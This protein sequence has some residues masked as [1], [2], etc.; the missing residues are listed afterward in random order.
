M[1][2]RGR[3]RYNPTIDYYLILGVSHAATTDEI[4]TAFRQRAKKL[5]PD[6]NPDNEATAQ[7]QRLSEAYAVLS[8]SASRAEYDTVRET[9]RPWFGRYD[10]PRY[11]NFGAS[12][13]QPG[14]RGMIAMLWTGP[15]RYVMIVLMVVI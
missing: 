2:R 3:V 4:Q 7:F 13:R 5:H 12:S 11:S 14:M 1:A 8:D 6:R 15:Y 9:R 10:V